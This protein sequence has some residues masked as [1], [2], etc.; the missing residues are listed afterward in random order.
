MKKQF[1]AF[2]SDQVSRDGTVFTV[3]A[4][5]D[6][7]WNNSFYGVPSNLSHDMHKPIGWAYSKG[8]FFE[9]DKVLSIG[10]FLIA[11]T[12]ED[13]KSLSD[14]R[15]KF[16]THRINVEIN[17]C[18]DDF[19]SELG[20]LYTGDDG[21]FANGVV[22]YGFNNIVLKAFPFLASQIN[23]DKD[24]LI[25][26]EIL[27]KDFEYISQGIFKEK[28]S[29][30]A[31]IAHPF[32][33]KSFSIYNNFH[34]IFLDELIS[35]QKNDGLSVKLKLDLDRV[36]YAPSFRRSYEFEYWWGPKYSDEI[37]TIPSGLTQYGSDEFEKLYYNILRTEFNWVN[38]NEKK[39]LECEEVKDQYAP[40]LS[41]TYACRYVH[42]IFDTNKKVFD[43]F[44]GAVRS[45]STDLMLDRIDKKLTE[46]GRRSDYKKIVQN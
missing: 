14:A 22:M 4:L 42:S 9:P 27:L 33:R 3:S 31:L 12:T 18:V 46:F 23:G 37:N 10:Y 24:G 39:T 6:G 38:E 34:W 7:I 11:V 17:N 43:H 44:D 19:K 30:M 1:A 5:E 29:E 13:E 28:K 41:D 20:E 16:L 8:L 21:W 36:G 26:L 32:F 40:T 45:Y 25:D 2:C 15:N 35:L